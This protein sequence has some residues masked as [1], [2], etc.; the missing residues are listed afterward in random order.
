MNCCDAVLSF[1][2]CVSSRAAVTCASTLNVQSFAYFN[3]IRQVAPPLTFYWDFLLQHCTLLS[4]KYKH[5]SR[6]SDKLTGL[7]SRWSVWSPKRKLI[8]RRRWWRR[9]SLN[10]ILYLC[11]DVDIL[12]TAAAAATLSAAKR[13]YIIPLSLLSCS[14]DLLMKMCVVSCNSL[15]VQLFVIICK[16]DGGLHGVFYSAALMILSYKLTV[17]ARNCLV[18]VW[19]NQTIRAP[20]NLTTVWRLRN[21][22]VVICI[23]MSGILASERWRDAWRPSLQ[24]WIQEPLMIRDRDGRP[25]RGASGSALLLCV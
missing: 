5:S 17:S 15:L 22:V 25:P 2:L 10:K 21:S 24:R 14:I 3:L 16:T 8:F 20:L 7:T 4:V 23:I 11:D 1:Q 13:Q 12:N 9:W 18:W 19:C 6:P